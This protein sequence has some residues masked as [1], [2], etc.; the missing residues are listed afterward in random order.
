MSF[1][2]IV[3]KIRDNLAGRTS[4]RMAHPAFRSSAVLV[5]FIEGENGPELVFTVRS[6][7]LK[8]HRGEISFPGGGRKKADANLFDTALREAHEEVGINPDQVT[9]LGELDDFCT[10]SGFILHPVVAT[11]AP[12]YDFR[13][14][15]AE[16]AEIFT[17]PLDFFQDVN[18]FSERDMPFGE[19]RYPVFSFQYGSHNI[20]G[21][22]AYVLVHLLEFG[23]GVTLPRT[24][25]QRPT[26]E[27]V[28]SLRGKVKPSSYYAPQ[29]NENHSDNQ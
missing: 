6:A 16:V 14:N 24:I 25:W 5:P 2:D 1:N 29:S 21:A 26:C 17:V 8:K 3:G 28:A 4:V 20:W 12:P 18:N 9:I 27:Q 23:L 15:E 10:M 11:V 7:K 19:F 22:T 13:P